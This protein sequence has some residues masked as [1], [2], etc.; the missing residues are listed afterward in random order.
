MKEL[1]ENII[2]GIVKNP[3]LVNIVEYKND[4]EVVFE[5]HVDPQDVGQIIGKDGRTIK[6]INT[7]LTAAKKDENTKFLL[8]VIR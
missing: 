5:I 4:A 8:K 6:S 1:L 2:K 7:L 3:E